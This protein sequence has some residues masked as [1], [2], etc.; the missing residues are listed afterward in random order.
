MPTTVQIHDRTLDRLKFFKEHER[1][2]YDEI[3]NKLMDGIEEGELSQLAIEG[4]IRGVHDAKSG[5][6]TPIGE[7]AEKWGIKLGG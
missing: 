7:L 1:E 4:I 3:L 2:S 5:K 6:V